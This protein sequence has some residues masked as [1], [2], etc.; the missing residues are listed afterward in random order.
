MPPNEARV[1]S[2]SPAGGVEERGRRSAVFLTIHAFFS[3][4]PSGGFATG[5]SSCLTD[6]YST[7]KE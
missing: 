3:G 4:E 1:A 5:V 7:M 2:A 6:K